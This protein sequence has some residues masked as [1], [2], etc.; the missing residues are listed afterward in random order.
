M[1]KTMNAAFI[2]GLKSLEIKNVPVPHV[3]QG[4]V[5][6]KVTSCSVCGSD[7]RIFDTGNK[8]VVYPAIIGHEVAGEVVKVGQGITRFRV[9][10]KVAL[11]ADIPCGAC[12]WCLN[13]MCNCCDKNYALGHQFPG[14]F[15]QYCLLNPLVVQFGAVSFV[16]EKTSMEEAALTEPLACCVNGM[17]KVNFTGG[18][19][20]LIFGAGPIG[21]LLAQLARVFGSTLVIV[22]DIDEKR[23]DQ[24]RLFKPDYVI[25][26]AKNN[27][28][29]IINNLTN[30]KG[31]DVIFTACAAANVHELSLSLV[32]K[33]GNINLFGGLPI[34]AGP[35][36]I[37]S[38]QIHYKEISV[39]GSHGSTPK[40]F[41]LAM[42]L[43]SSGRINVS[44]LITHHFPLVDLEKAFETVRNRE[45]LKIVVNP[46]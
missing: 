10:D 30:G 13:G 19:S 2:T 44:S 27:L 32:A 33:R 5:L 16:S 26:S 36:N 41:D 21:L 28:T 25:N 29:N 46:W 7:I 4:T 38:N 11:G 18:K 20:V 3:E 1:L 23:L 42:Q 39:T 40:Q 43:I 22:V 17:E 45:G 14:G 15:A 35:I 6:V 37:F 9:G 24:A 8:R 31:V 12:E 34:T